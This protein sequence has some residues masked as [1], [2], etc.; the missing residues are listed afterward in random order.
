M[1]MHLPVKAGS[2]R[3]SLSVWTRGAFGLA[4][5]LWC[6]DAAKAE[7]LPALRIDEVQIA[8]PK[9]FAQVV[10]TTNQ[11]MRTQHEV[12]LFLRA[13]GATSLTGEIISAFT[14]SPAD[15]FETLKKNA[16][17]FSTDP[18]LS[19]M[20]EKMNEIGRSGPTTWLKAVRF[21]GT[22]A[23]GWLLNTLVN[24]SSESALLARVAE[25]G[26]LLAQ[27]GRPPPKLNVFRVIAGRGGYTHLVSLN[28]ASERDLAARMDA[29]AA[30][31]WT[32]EFSGPSGVSCVIIQS[33]IYGELLP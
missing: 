1:I 24:A 10:A 5:L 16:A 26:A 27:S 18:D 21:D 22:H 20:R 31:G 28:E 7:F 17:T 32:L 23:P 2:G 14:L 29:I 3:E 4:V 6:A 33:T 9:R 13:Y 30:A 8:D 25:L 11:A 12:P 15:S 19:A